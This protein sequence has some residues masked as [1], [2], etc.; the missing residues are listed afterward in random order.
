[1]SHLLALLNDIRAHRVAL[2]VGETSL[3]K[4]AD[5]LRGCEYAIDRLLPHEQDHFLADFR[6]WIYQRFGTTEN[7]SWEKIILRHSPDETEAVKRFWE[8]LDE[9]LR[10]R[11]KP[12]GPS[13]KA[14]VPAPDGPADSA[15]PSPARH[16]HGDPRRG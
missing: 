10:Q 16:P 7:V 3:S 6:G 12:E 4:L 2:Y 5:F 9:Y 8:L 15:A 1:M 11:K 13:A 14:A